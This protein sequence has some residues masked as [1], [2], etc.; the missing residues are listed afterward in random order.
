M[1][2]D[3]DWT[4]EESRG[5]GAWLLWRGHR[6]TRLTA[7]RA[8]GIAAA[9]NTEEGAAAFKATRDAINAGGTR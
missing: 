2:D 1:P 6:V 3:N 9:L 5:A 7:A 4:V 8:H